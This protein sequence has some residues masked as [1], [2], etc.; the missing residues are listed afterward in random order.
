MGERDRIRNSKEV[1]EPNI[2]TLASC[3]AGKQATIPEK[4]ASEQNLTFAVAHYANVL[5]SD[6]YTA[7][8]HSARG[9][10]GITKVS[11]AASLGACRAL[12]VTN[13]S[14]LSRTI[15]V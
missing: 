1:T 2:G 15:L 6:A 8:P 13:R 9:A 12:R 5:H 14:S 7:Y 11:C 10:T 3:Q 4:K